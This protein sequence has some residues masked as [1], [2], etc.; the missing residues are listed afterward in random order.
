MKKILITGGLGFIGYFLVKKHLELGHKVIVFDS[1]F[2]NKGG[3]DK[4]FKKVL[5]HKN[6]KLFYHVIAFYFNKKNTFIF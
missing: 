5:I 6:L 1:F 3:I 4:E 2:K